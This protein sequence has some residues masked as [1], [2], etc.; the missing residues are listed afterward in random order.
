MNGQTVR[1]N[2]ADIA[3]FN[4]RLYGRSW[5]PYL[6][7]KIN[8]SR[9]F[10]LTDF[11]EVGQCAFTIVEIFFG[12]EQTRP[13]DGDIVT[14]IQDSLTGDF[15]AVDKHA[16]PAVHISHI[17][18]AAVG[19]EANPHM[20]TRDSVLQYLYEKGLIAA[21]HICSPSERVI[22]TFLVSGHYK[23]RCHFQLRKYYKLAIHTSNI[24]EM[25]NASR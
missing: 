14:V 6:L 4:Y 12:E 9:T 24:I 13:S 21:N 18:L 23:D 11:L 19:I 16:V 17:M 8:M 22:V 5:K 25:P 10:P 15:A 3:A 7:V 2:A 20:L 1:M